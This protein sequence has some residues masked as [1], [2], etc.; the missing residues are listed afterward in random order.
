MTQLLQAQNDRLSLPNLI[1]TLRPDLCRRFGFDKPQNASAFLTWL[2]TTGSREY[3]ALAQDAGFRALLDGKDDSAGLS[4][5]QQCLWDARPDVHQAFAGPQQRAAFEQWFLVHGVGEHRLWP[6]LTPQQQRAVLYQD[7]PWQA[8]LLSRAV[9][10]LAQEPSLPVQQR[11]WGVNLIG[12]VYGQLGIGEDVRMAA[13]ALLAAGVPM[14][15]LDFPPGKNVPQNDRSMAAYVSTEG[16]YAFNVFCLTALEHGRYFAERGTAGQLQGRYNIGYWP[17][18]LSRWPEAWKDLVQLVDEVWVSSKHTFEAVAPA[19]AALAQPVPVRL[20]PM[21][22]ELG[23]VANLGTRAEVRARF[24]LPAQ[25]R[26]FVFTFDLNSSIHRKN[27]QAVVDAFLRAFAADTWDREQVGLVIR[28][29]RPRRVSHLWQRLKALAA[30]DPRLHLSEGTLQRPELLALYQACD[31]FVSLHRVE[32]FGRGIAEALQLGLHVIT[33][34]YSGNVDFCQAP[35]VADRVDLVRHRLVKVRRGQYPFGD[36]Q[37]WAN[38]DIGHAAQCL[39][40]FVQRFV[41]GAQHLPPHTVPAE[42]WPMFGAPMVG[43]R[44]RQRL[45]EVWT[46]LQAQTS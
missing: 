25:A 46:A 24:G 19:C 39:Q 28:T 36:G 43:Q 15:L 23:T 12:Y 31:A 1:L 44:Y 5:L 8:D 6:F 3:A 4:R 21:T 27:P 18:E 9:A 2:V 10:E 29:G 41:P 33:T 42:G 34:G 37:V 26:L 16:P 7:G 40:A 14:T 20:M 17:W 32:G 13:K 22:V 30:A 45:Q 35:E 38:A 11:A